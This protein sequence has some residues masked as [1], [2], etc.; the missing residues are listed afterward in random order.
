M[1]KYNHYCSKVFILMGKTRPKYKLVKGLILVS[2]LV[3]CFLILAAMDKADVIHKI[4][5]PIVKPDCGCDC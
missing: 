2:I 5:A 3:S 1:T 4:S